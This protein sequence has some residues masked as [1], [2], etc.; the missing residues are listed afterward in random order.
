MC[1]NKVWQN[2]IYIMTSHVTV[3]TQDTGEIS[4]LLGILY[5]AGVQKVEHLNIWELW[6]KDRSAS[7]CFRATMSR[8]TFI[9]RY[10][11]EFMV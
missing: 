10:Y 3:E 7:E 1:I 11:C 4:A 2:C 6:N 5:I 9:T 8:A